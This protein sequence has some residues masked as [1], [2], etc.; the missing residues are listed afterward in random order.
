MQYTFIPPLHLSPNIMDKT[1]KMEMF[2]NHNYV[3]IATMKNVFC[4]FP[5]TNK[6]LN[7]IILQVATAQ[8]S[9]MSNIIC[10]FFVVYIGLP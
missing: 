5:V 8:I 7:D 9:T 1:I 3:A 2:F 4:I 10:T 6:I